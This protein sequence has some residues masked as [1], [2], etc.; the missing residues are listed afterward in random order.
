M[1]KWFYT[2]K[3]ETKKLKVNKKCKSH[4]TMYKYAKLTQKNKKKHQTDT[5]AVEL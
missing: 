2:T 5:S 3:L 4:K 1:P